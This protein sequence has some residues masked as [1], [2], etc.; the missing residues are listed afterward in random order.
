M[1]YINVFAAMQ[2]FLFA[3]LLWK[4]NNDN[5]LNKL[6]AFLLLILGVNLLGNTL[7]L[8]GL[9]SPFL[10]I[11]FFLTQGV[12]LLIAP[13]IFYYLNLLSGKKTRL[14]HPLFLLSFMLL[15][16]VF[17]LGVNFSFQSV[18]FKRF[19]VGNLREGKYPFEMKFF[20][21]LFILLQHT[22][23][24]ISW[25]RVY[26]FKKVIKDVFST[27]SRTKNNFAFKF[28]SLIWILDMLLVFTYL[29]VP[30]Y[31]VQYIVI[32]SKTIVA[33]SFILYFILEQNVIFNGE[34]Y[35]EYLKDI[36]LLKKAIVENEAEKSCDELGTELI[37]ET[38]VTQRMYLNPTITIFDLSK[39]LN[40][41]HRL[42]SA[43]IN[44]QYQKTFSGLVN[45][46]RV[47]EAKTIL[48]NNPKNLTMEGVGLES[49]F[50]S[51]ASF[52]RVFKQS[53]KLTP[54]E[55][56]KKNKNLQ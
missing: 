7:V 43:S 1:I 8:S 45:D 12:S 42:I 39:E 54:M 35:Q 19:Y 20:Y 53:T 15:C 38:L 5:D 3:F 24:T 33:F 55:F 17:Y 48:K 26:K 27:R 18:D 28:I 32:P 47:E 34:S 44:Q 56:M 50:N 46:L 31:Q 49:G 40:C 4:N 10:Y 25:L 21:W 16:Y 2:T 6:L 9:L 14:L 23:F 37:K 22:Y 29:I 52:Y 36:A 41:S 51:R 13:I 30:I 11:F